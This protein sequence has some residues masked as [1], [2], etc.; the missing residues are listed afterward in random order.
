MG[1][2]AADQFDQR[3]GL[4]CTA[5]IKKAPGTPGLGDNLRRMS[6]APHQTLRC[7]PKAQIRQGADRVSAPT[8]RC[9]N[10][11]PGRPSAWRAGC[12]AKMT[13]TNAAGTL[14]RK[15]GK[16]AGRSWTVRNNCTVRRC[17]LL[18]DA[19]QLWRSCCCIGRKVRRSLFRKLSS[20]RRSWPAS[21]SRIHPIQPLRFRKLRGDMPFGEPFG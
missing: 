8:R 20:C 18:L 4:Q 7:Y 1:G 21:Y 11:G 15:S 13:K 19:R 17:S 14:S 9:R 12:G 6:S 5:S 2:Y 3:S 10:D 16:A